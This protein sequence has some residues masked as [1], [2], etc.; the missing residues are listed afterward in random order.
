[1]DLKDLALKRTRVTFEYDGEP[2]TIEFFPNQL[3]AE[4]FARTSE[5]AQADMGPDGDG[6]CRALAAI[7]I[8]WDVQNAGQPFPPTYENLKLV[9]KALIRRTMEE[10]THTLGKLGTRSEANG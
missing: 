6:E 8:D 4:W 10:V 9:P 3:T 7:L 1:M 2:V 5:Q